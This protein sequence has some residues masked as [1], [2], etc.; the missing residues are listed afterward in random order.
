MF[1]Q[2]KKPSHLP[3]LKHINYFSML[4]AYERLL[5]LSFNE[6]IY[7]RFNELQSLDLNQYSL[8]VNP[9][10]LFYFSSI[11][12]DIC[13]LFVLH[14]MIH[15]HSIFLGINYHPLPKVH[16]VCFILIPMKSMNQNKRFSGL[17]FILGF[18]LL[19][20]D[21]VRL[22]PAM[23]VNLLSYA[24]LFNAHSHIETLRLAIIFL[25]NY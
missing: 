17:N 16:R 23:S 24:I 3:I 19:L 20:W 14:P 5:K 1:Y 25:V 15:Q 9:L 2:I 22:W 4:I 7:L 12:Y 8:L 13:L 10:I 6:M 18:L 11:L 21:S